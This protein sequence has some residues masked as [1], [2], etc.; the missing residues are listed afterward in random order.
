[1]TLDV[2]CDGQKYPLGDLYYS[3]TKGVYVSTESVWG[4]YQLA[5]DLAAGYED[6]YFFSDAFAKDLKVALDQ[7]K[8][9]QLLSVEDMGL[10]EDEMEAVLPQGGFGDLYDAVFTFYE[11]VFKGFSSNMVTE[12]SGGYK[13]ETDGRAVAQLTADM[14]DF[15][16]TNPDQVLNAA[17]AYV[18]EVM[19][20]MGTSEEEMA[21]LQTAFA[22]MRAQ[23]GEFVTVMGSIS[24]ALKGLM[25]E[26]AAAVVLDQFHYAGTVKKSGN[27]FVSDATYQLTNGDKNVIR[28]ATNATIKAAAAHI[29]FPE[30]GMTAAEL[31]T[32]VSTLM[33]RYNPVTG[34]AMAGGWESSATMA[35]LYE[36][37]AEETPFGL[38]SGA[39]VTDMLIR[40]G[41]AYLPLRTICDAL[42][43]TV[44]WNKEEKTAYVVKDG[45][46]IPMQGL[47]QDG[48]SFVSIRDFETLGYTVDYANTD[49]L[50]EAVIQK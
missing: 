44:A 11:D 48:K 5:D 32:K 47:L 9:I 4:M 30:S 19:M 13:I 17:E 45:K 49:G 22:D 12:I 14:L 24:A 28:V 7:E 2:T 34:V 23:K 31:G 15:L 6:S 38:G 20:Q 27:S 10:T 36:I 1:M 21:M 16:A 37:R 25:A 26:D 29:Q 35:T 46:D 41:R 50:K 43:E 39:E 42:G 3:L 40:D 8:Y 33:D 18:K